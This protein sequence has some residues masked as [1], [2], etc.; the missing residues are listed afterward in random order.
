MKT[1][2]TGR[3]KIS[4]VIRELQT[5]QNKYGDLNVFGEGTSGRSLTYDIDEI[6]FQTGSFDSVM[7][8]FTN[9]GLM[10]PGLDEE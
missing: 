3:R 6:R 10:Y 9:S 2:K 1:K 7:F 5:L 4:D 8:T